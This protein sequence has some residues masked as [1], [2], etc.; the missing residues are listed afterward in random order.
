MQTDETSGTY[1]A[2]PEVADALEMLGKGYN[3]DPIPP[4]E[5]V[6]TVSGFT[7]APDTIINE[8]GY[9]TALVWGVAWRFCQMS[10]GV[11]RAG[12]EKIAARLG[13]SERTIIRHLDTLCDGGFLFDTTPT[14]KNKPHIYADTGKIKVRMNIHAMTESQRAVTESQRHGDRESVEESIKKE[15]KDYKKPKT[16]LPPGSDI[17]YMLAAHMTSEDIAASQSADEIE[18][19]LLMFYESKMGYGSTLDWWGKNADLVALR[20]FLVTQSRDNIEVF[21]K[22]C[23][24]TY[25]KFRPEDAARFPRN[26][27]TFW[28]LA[29]EK[30]EAETVKD[31]GHWL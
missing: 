6:A 23:K 26:V 20:K 17:G 8:Y 30:A 13:M 3:T 29:F 4:N 16:K 11:C 12:L 31:G 25:S 22:W 24:R 1:I 28:P 19:G 7:L 14:L 27:L 2:D 9:V 15:S 21:A 5:F 18:R 10:D